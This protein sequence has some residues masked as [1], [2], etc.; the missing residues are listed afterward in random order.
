MKVSIVTA[1]LDRA[2]TI[3]HAVRSVQRQSYRDVEHVI[4]DGGSKDGT[5]EIIERLGDR[6][7]KLIS[8]PDHGIYDAVN[9]G[10]A[11]ST[12]DVVGLLHSD[13]FFHMMRW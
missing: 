1:V 12:G 3:G 2:D 7:T 5:V 10:I 9:R 6:R 4:Q 13:D 8:E 11:R